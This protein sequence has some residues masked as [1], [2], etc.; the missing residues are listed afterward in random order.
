MKRNKTD[1]NTEKKQRYCIAGIVT[2]IAALITALL[3]INISLTGCLFYPKELVV[4]APSLIAPEK[5]EFITVTA[6]K[7]NLTKQII[8]TAYFLAT[9]KVDV[10]FKATGMT[11]GNLYVKPGDYVEKGQL[12]ASADKTKIL[13]NIESKKLD[14]RKAL[15]D[16]ARLHARN[17]TQ[18]QLE[19]AELTV[20][21][22]ELQ[23]E[24]YE[25]QLEKTDITAPVAGR[26][27]YA[28]SAL[29]RGD[30]ITV[31]RTI[32]RL[33]DESSVKLEYNLSVASEKDRNLETFARMGTPA[34]VIFNSRE[35][36]AEVVM[37][38]YQASKTTGLTSTNVIWLD[39][40]G[41]DQPALPGSYAKVI[42]TVDT[43][44]NVMIVGRDLLQKFGSG[45]YVR[46]LE[47]G[48]KVERT[49]KLGLE[50]ETYAEVLQG[51]EEGEKI[52]LK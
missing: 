31:N 37:T 47:D 25:L 38:P 26:V 18:Y 42:F 19:S 4:P 44:E 13:D 33:I 36:D 43:R 3:L 35:Y 23:L 30:S 40:K 14:I 7:G 48:Y 20:R 24:S 8:I 2:R 10:G 9:E 27:I 32:V 22:R 49:V 51:I 46:V 28:N 11:F 12:L 1:R 29:K 39:V 41:L 34:K 5:A 15:I 21:Q 50:T 52:I 17:G 45:Y 16:L 6:K